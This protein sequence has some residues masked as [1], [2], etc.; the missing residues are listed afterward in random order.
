M[1]SPADLLYF[2]L[3]DYEVEINDKS[4][5]LSMIVSWMS[6]NQY[7]LDKYDVG[8]YDI[9]RGFKV[10]DRQLKDYDDLKLFRE[11]YRVGIDSLDAKGWIFEN[12][13]RGSLGWN[14]RHGR[15]SLRDKKLKAK[16]IF[17][18]T[19]NSLV[20]LICNVE[21]NRFFKQKLWAKA[22]KMNS[23]SPLFP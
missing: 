17:V 18:T 1:L 5:P 16:K 14:F 20:Y 19:T 12:L 7:K 15:E 3:N 9:I 8:V 6:N 2:K 10:Y 13:Y 22:K 23:P 4:H 11:I 21:K